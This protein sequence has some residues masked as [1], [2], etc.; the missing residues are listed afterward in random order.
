M[1]E[2]ESKAQEAE[3]KK[4]SARRLASVPAP[5]DEAVARPL[6]R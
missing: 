3:R 5:G 2:A 4:S 1:M 6:A